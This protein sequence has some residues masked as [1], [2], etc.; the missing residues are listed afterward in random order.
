MKDKASYKSAYE[1]WKNKMMEA[2]KEKE[3][4]PIHEKSDKQEENWL[5]WEEVDKK[6]SDLKEEI[7]SLPSNKAIV[8]S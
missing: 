3:A 1:Y 5:N 6:K 7:S 8:T 2:R 4:K